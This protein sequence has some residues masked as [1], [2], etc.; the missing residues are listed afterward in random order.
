V[1]AVYTIRTRIIKPAI[2]ADNAKAAQSSLV[3]TGSAPQ[4]LAKV[5]S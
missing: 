1:Y 2:G 5:D 3:Q 4:K